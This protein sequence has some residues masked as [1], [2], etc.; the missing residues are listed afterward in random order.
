MKHPSALAVQGD[1]LYVVD[2]GRGVLVYQLPGPA[3]AT[4]P[5]VAQAPAP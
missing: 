2:R 4:A 5:I 3:Q 1:K